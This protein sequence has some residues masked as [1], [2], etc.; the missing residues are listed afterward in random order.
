MDELWQ[1]QRDCIEKAKDLDGFALFCDPGT[2]KSRT[3]LEMIIKKGPHNVLILGPLVVV[4]QW[5]R[6][7]IRFSNINPKN[8][9]TFDKDGLYKASL[10]AS[11]TSPDKKIVITNFETLY[12]PKCF[13]FFMGFVEI[14]ICDESSRLKNPSAK[15]TKQAIKLADKAKYRYILSGT[16]ILGSQLDIFS[17]FRILDGGKTFGKNYFLFRAKYF[18]DKNATWRGSQNY[19]PDWQ[20]KPDCNKKIQDAIRPLSFHITKEEALD[21]PALVKE[22]VLVELTPGQRK[23]YNSMKD[24]LIAFLN[25]KACVAEMALTKCLRLQQMVSGFMRFDDDTE[26]SWDDFAKLSALSDLLED[27]APNHKVIVWAIFKKNYAD[28]KKVCDSLKLPYAEL[29]GEISNKDVEIKRFMED[30]SCRVLIAN[31]NAGGLGVNLTAAS[32]AIFYSRGFGLE[33]DIQA[34]ARNHR[35]GTD[36]ALAYMGKDI[37]VTRIDLIVK[38]SIDELIMFAI[39]SKLDTSNAI[40][41]M[42]R[43]KLK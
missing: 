18:Y 25:D 24:S 27:I 39:K 33:A 21:L 8:I 5:K 28:I 6:E 38:D 4:Q 34:E 37:K 42:L 10:I 36:I 41:G 1:H 35:G 29:H 30:A 31:P 12:N 3:A 19:F 14:L 13:D 43:E 17:Q 22:E 9:F 16:P 20:P 15:R 7:F 32:Y 40:L 11:M 2:G 26:K 23:A